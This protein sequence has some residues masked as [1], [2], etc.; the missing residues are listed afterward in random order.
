MDEECK[1]KDEEG[2]D[3]NEEGKK[4][5]EGCKEEEVEVEAVDVQEP[6]S[7]LVVHGLSEGDKTA[8]KVTHIEERMMRLVYKEF[9]VIRII[10][11]YVVEAKPEI[12]KEWVKNHIRNELARFVEAQVLQGKLVDEAQKGRIVKGAMMAAQAK[13]KDMSA[14]DKSRILM[15]CKDLQATCQAS[16]HFEAIHLKDGEATESA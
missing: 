6:A 12:S 5:D 11:Q 7:G 14:K 15:T 3:E 4:E 13:N 1:G 9:E 2:K 10:S 16:F 8:N